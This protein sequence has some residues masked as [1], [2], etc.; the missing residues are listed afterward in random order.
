M[1][2][3]ESGAPYP[4]TSN[5][6]KRLFFQPGILERL[7]QLIARAATMSFSA[8]IVKLRQ[9]VSFK[10]FRFVENNRALVSESILERI[11][12]AELVKQRAVYKMQ[13][14]TKEIFLVKWVTGGK[15]DSIIALENQ[16]CIHQGLDIDR[17]I[18][19]GGTACEVEFHGCRIGGIAIHVQEHGLREVLEEPRVDI[20]E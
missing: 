13:V 17:N 18:T 7:C 8:C 9:S 5:E 14:R 4:L 16:S 6:F 19:R 10:Y 11:S 20:L 12:S 3:T 2:P 1:S 15:M